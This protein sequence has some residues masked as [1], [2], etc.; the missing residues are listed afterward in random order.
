MFASVTNATL[1]A[2][3]ELD[4]I[5]SKINGIF[6]SCQQFV[7]TGWWDGINSLCVSYVLLDHCERKL[8]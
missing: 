6:N 7:G 5:D 3:I 8:R 2:E 1:I 4:A